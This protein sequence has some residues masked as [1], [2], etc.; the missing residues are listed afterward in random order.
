VYIPK[1]IFLLANYG[2]KM[3]AKPSSAT[4]IITVE[5]AQTENC[6]CVGCMYEMMI[7]LVQQKLACPFDD[8]FT[9]MMMM[10]LHSDL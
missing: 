6:W 2:N 5:G 1:L 3:A 8:E 10:I 4:I 7:I 9:M